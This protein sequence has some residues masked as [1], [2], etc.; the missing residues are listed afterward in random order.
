MAWAPFGGLFVVNK[1]YQKRA[2][3]ASYL[4]LFIDFS[5]CQ[6]YFQAAK[7]EVYTQKLGRSPHYLQNRRVPL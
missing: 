6:T 1:F 5:R 2:R 3:A 4:S 7:F